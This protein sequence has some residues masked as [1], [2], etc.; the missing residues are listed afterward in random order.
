M[1]IIEA[2]RRSLLLITLFK[3]Q[4]TTFVPLSCFIFACLF[5]LDWAVYGASEGGFDPQEKR[6]HRGDNKKNAA[7]AAATAASASADD[8]KSSDASSSSSSAAASDSSKPE[9]LER[10]VRLACD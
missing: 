4:V 6:W 8:T 10:K 2:E 5:I 7:A 3:H 9:L 1:S